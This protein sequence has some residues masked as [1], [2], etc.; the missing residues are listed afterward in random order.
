MLRFLFFNEEV[1]YLYICILALMIDFWDV[2]QLSGDVSQLCGDVSQLSRD[3]SQLSGTKFSGKI[4]FGNLE[5][6]F[7]EK[8]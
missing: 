1:L 2:S 6:T 7:P 3:V 8:T 4:C 5:I